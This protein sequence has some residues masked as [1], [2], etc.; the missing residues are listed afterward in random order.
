MRRIRR[1]GSCRRRV[2][3]RGCGFPGA[4]VR[5]DSGARIKAARCQS[6]TTVDSKLITWGDTRDHACNGAARMVG[7]R[8]A[9]DP[10]TIRS[11]SG[12][13]EDEDFKAAASTRRS[14]TAS[15][16]P[17]ARRFR[18]LSRPTRISRRWPPRS[19]TSRNRGNRRNAADA[20]SRWRDA[21]SGRAPMTS[22]RDRRSRAHR[23]VVQGG[24]ASRRLDGRAHIVDVRRIDESSLSM[25]VQSG[26]EGM[27]VRSI[28]ASFARRA[29]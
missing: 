21:G 13:S 12:F 27:P 24:R 5:D 22:S 16:A 10:D 3:S 11:S 15:S 29:R 9:R 2:G 18:R 17:T 20:P 23:Q 6:S 7:V 28:D 26:A 14:S 25:L 4:G 1:T 8:S 19:Y